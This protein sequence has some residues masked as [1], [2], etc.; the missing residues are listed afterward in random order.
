MKKL[1]IIIGIAAEACVFAALASECKD[2]QVSQTDVGTSVQNVSESGKITREQWNAMTPEQRRE[3]MAKS[4]VDSAS[5]RDKA[6]AAR[7]GIPLE[8]W[9]TMTKKGRKTIRQEALAK[10]KGMTVEQMKAERTRKEAEKVG[11]PVEK[12]AAMTVKERCAYRKAA[13]EAKEP[14]QS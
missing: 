1:M 9:V 8:K 7:L 12:W 14:K 2:K 5:S 3:A 4:K 11:C 6:E 10:S 13:K